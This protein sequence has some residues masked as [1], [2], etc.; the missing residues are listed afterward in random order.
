MVRPGGSV[1]DE[2][3][4]GSTIH[5]DVI[6]PEQTDD[7]NVSVNPHAAKTIDGGYVGS[8]ELGP[9]R[10]SIIDENEHVNR[11]FVVIIS[12]GANDDGVTK[13]SHAAAKIIIGGSI[14]SQNLGL[15]RPSTIDPA[16]QV[17]RSARFSIGVVCIGGDDDRIAG[18]SQVDAKI[19]RAATTGAT[20]FA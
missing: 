12:F 18:Y 5:S 19:C 15:I 10:P 11:S 7:K 1:S 3:V 17:G 8:H 16:E 2:Y 14:R 20:S 4:R 9:I 13:N 6:V